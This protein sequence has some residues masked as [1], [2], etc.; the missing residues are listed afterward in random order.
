MLEE[1]SDEAGSSGSRAGGATSAATV[2]VDLM[3]KI[4][5]LGLQRT[6]PRQKVLD[7]L[8]LAR[9]IQPLLQSQCLLMK[10]DLQVVRGTAPQQNQH[11]QRRP[12]M[13]DL[14]GPEQGTTST[15]EGAADAKSVAETRAHG[16]GSACTSERGRGSTRAC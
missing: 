8:G 7:H 15:A 4:G 14:L 16:R 3:M 2:A 11:Q 10:L 6:A 5:L 12:L 9:P 13:V 1:T